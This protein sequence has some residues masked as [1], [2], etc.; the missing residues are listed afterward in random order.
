MHAKVGAVEWR[1][2][3]HSLS[4]CIK[5]M[6]VMM[7]M[8]TMNDDD[9]NEGHYDDENDGYYENGHDN[10]MDRKYIVFIYNSKRGEDE[11]GE[12]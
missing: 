9:E 5:M 4:V 12:D 2:M 8:M 7:M 11:G 3:P 1:G 10:V 6:M